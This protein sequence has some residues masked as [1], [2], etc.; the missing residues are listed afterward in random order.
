[1][2]GAWF[3]F[4][5]QNHEHVVYQKAQDLDNAITI[6]EETYH[7]P[8]DTEVTFEPA[9]PEDKIARLTT[10]NDVTSRLNKGM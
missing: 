1:M 9:H 10:R 3:G 4:V 7:R 2:M 5:Q 8:K 6:H